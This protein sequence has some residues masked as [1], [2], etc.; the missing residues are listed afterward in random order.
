MKFLE[1][2]TYPTSQPGW[3]RVP[4]AG[5]LMLLLTACAAQRPINTSLPL[6][7]NTGPEVQVADVDVLVVSPAMEAFLAR[8]ILPYR[9]L[10]TRLNLLTVAVANSGVLGFYYDEGRT[11]TSE[12]AF[13]T[14]SGNCIGFANMLVALARRSGLKASYQEVFLRPEWSS[15]EDI[16]LRTKHIN[17]VVASPRHSF[18]IDVS[19]LKFKPKVHKRILSDRE[20]KA[21]Y[22]NNIGVDAL[23]E[24]QLA[25]AY[26]YIAKAIDVAPRVAGPWVNLGVI[27]SRNEQLD[28]AELAHQTAL[29]INAN[30]YAAMSNLYEVYLAQE[31][32][33]A[34]REIQ[35]KVEKYRQKNPY[36]LLQLS[37][38]A[39]EQAN[40]EESASLLRRAIR[41]KEDEHLLHFALAKTQYLSGQSAAAQS[42]LNRARELAPEDM[43]AHYARPLQELVGLKK[44]GHHAKKSQVRL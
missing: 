27:Y 33:A 21:L 24:N 15:H 41:T 14:R 10:N 6:L 32:L 11:V 42:S 34:A 29:Q 17:V 40:F 38:E 39:L 26:A 28:D 9:N 13:E 18:V 31:D 22:F 35:S 16:L 8:Y 44:P 1:A 37:D 30:E 3:A 4:L 2:S 5:M 20:A 23:L 25:T 43:L 7:H 12:E 19:G 36:Y